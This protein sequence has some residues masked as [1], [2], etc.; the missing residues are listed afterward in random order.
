[1]KHSVTFTL[2]IV[3]VLFATSLNACPLR[4]LTVSQYGLGLSVE[5]ENRSDEAVR[6][7]TLIVTYSDP[8]G[9]YH[10][11]EFRSGVLLHARQA[12]R[13]RTPP[14]EGIVDWKSVGV[15][16]TCAPVSEQ[17]GK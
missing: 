15:T 13:L 16:A 14:L 12:V 6:I 10:E 7:G 1:M 5:V 4:V 9:K 11:K 2:G 17:D 8:L 3:A